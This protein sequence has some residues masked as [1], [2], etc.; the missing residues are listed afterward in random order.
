MDGILSPFL[1]DLFSMARLMEIT[2]CRYLGTWES[3]S[4]RIIFR[5]IGQAFFRQKKISPLETGTKTITLA[6]KTFRK[7]QRMCEFFTLIQ[8]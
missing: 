5:F 4:Y 3:G 8:V 1:S 7:K 6:V 2:I